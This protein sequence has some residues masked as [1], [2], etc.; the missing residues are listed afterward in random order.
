MTCRS[1]P[2]HGKW[3]FPDAEMPAGDLDLR[4][5]SRVLA[6]HQAL[7]LAAGALQGRRCDLC[8]VRS[9]PGPES[10]DSTGHVRSEPVP[11]PS[12]S[13]RL[14]VSPE[15]NCFLRA[16]KFQPFQR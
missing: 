3:T 12:G 13:F 2:C 6:A 5:I 9:M 1:E 15:S 14:K 10:Y 11:S 4:G 16:A 7:C 8:M